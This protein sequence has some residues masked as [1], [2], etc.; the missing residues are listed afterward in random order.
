MH[1]LFL[2]KLNKTK[3]AHRHSLVHF[4]LVE[5]WQSFKKQLTAISHWSRYVIS[6]EM[7]WIWKT[8]ATAS[9]GPPHWNMAQSE[10]FIAKAVCTQHQPTNTQQHIST[11]TDQRKSPLF[12]LEAMM[13]MWSLWPTNKN[14]ENIILHIH[15]D[16][17]WW[18][19]CRWRQTCIETHEQQSP[20]LIL[21]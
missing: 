15:H 17:I 9:F 16:D 7:T 20:P 18:H 10:T 2:V 21:Q 19:P 12:Q 13:D 3:K 5:V 14:N 6:C 4:T 11:S 1:E 8:I